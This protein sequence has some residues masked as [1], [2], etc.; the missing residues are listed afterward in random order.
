MENFKVSI[1]QN[2]Y[3]AALLDALFQRCVTVIIQ[4]TVYESL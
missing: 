3:V 2:G 4:S 1:Q